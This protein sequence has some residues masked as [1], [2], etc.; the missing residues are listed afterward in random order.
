MVFFLSNASS[1]SLDYACFS[2][3]LVRCSLQWR[4]CPHSN[5]ISS[6]ISLSGCML[7]F[8][9]TCILNL[10]LDFEDVCLSLTFASMA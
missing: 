1:I 8:D 9:L 7:S 6:G 3:Q 2:R 5:L 4:Q 10:T